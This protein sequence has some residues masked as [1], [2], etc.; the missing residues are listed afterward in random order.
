M[1]YRRLDSG[2]M[3]FGQG[4]VNFLIDSAECVAQAVKTRLD[5][6]LGEW[7]MDTS[8]GMAWMNVAGQ[9]NLAGLDPILRKRILGTPGVAG[10][11][12]L[13]TVFDPDTREVSVTAEVVTKYGTTTLT[14]V[15]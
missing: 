1:R 5:L 11:N 7:F 2:D 14:A 4:G 6:W 9:K 12:S 3:T 15:T 8:D 13:L 10:I